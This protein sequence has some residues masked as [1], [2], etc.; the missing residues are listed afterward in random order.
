MGE[1][2]ASS[3]KFILVMVLV[4]ILALPFYGILLFTAIGP[5]ILYY[6]INGYLMGREYYE[7]VA[8]RR[9]PPHFA[10]DLRR[11]HRGRIGFTA[12]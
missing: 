5:L 7:V 8:F 6:L 1:A 11:A 9:L 2:V 12:R 4:N 10:R 3:L